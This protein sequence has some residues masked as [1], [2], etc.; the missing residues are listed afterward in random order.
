MNEKKNRRWNVTNTIKS[1]RLSDVADKNVFFSVQSIC[2][3]H[4]MKNSIERTNKHDI[5]VVKFDYLVVLVRSLKIIIH[6]LYVMFWAFVPLHPNQ[7]H[8]FPGRFISIN[9]G[10]RRTCVNIIHSSKSIHS[11]RPFSFFSMQ[12]F[13]I[14]FCIKWLQPPFPYTISTT[15]LIC[16]NATVWFVLFCGLPFHFTSHQHIQSFTN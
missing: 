9:N 2:L 8:S 13:M 14:T 1:V 10:V 16:V 5:G 7:T 15:N 11:F 4:L 3:R 6:S 12:I